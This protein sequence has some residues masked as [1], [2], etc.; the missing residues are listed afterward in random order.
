MALSIFEAA[1][2][3]ERT[4]RAPNT[5]RSGRRVWDDSASA[6]VESGSKTRDRFNETAGRTLHAVQSICDAL[7]PPSAG[8]FTVTFGGRT[9]QTHL[10]SRQ[11]KVT[12]EPLYTKGLRLADVADT[13]T[14]FVVHEIG[15][16]Q[17]SGDTDRLVTE[18]LTN[19]REY[20]R[21]KS[22][23]DALSNVLDDHALEVWAKHR[24]PGIAHTFRVTTKFVAQEQGLVN[25]PP[26]KWNPDADYTE[27]FNFMVVSV[28]YRWFT[29]WVSDPATKAERNW[30]VNWA[31]EYGD[32]S[33][34]AKR[35][36]G[37]KVGLARL[38]IKP[39]DRTEPEPE[40]EPQPD[41]SGQP[42]QSEDEDEAQPSDDQPD[43]FDLGDEDDDDD[44]DTTGGG[45]DDDDEEDGDG[46]DGED[47]DGES[48]EDDEPEHQPLD[49]D[50][51]GTGQPEDDDDTAESDEDEDGDD[52]I[53][54][55]GYKVETPDEA[56]D[57]NESEDDADGDESDGTDNGTD[58]DDDATDLPEGE[59]GDDDG[60]DEAEWDDDDHPTLDTDE[61]DLGK[62]GEGSDDAPVYESFEPEDLKPREKVQTLDDYTEERERSDGLRDRTLQKEVEVEMRATKVTDTNGYGSMKIEINL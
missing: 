21:W 9:A 2:E 6:Y 59:A 51:E 22:S 45:N 20:L 60:E 29:R 30:W 57:F 55:G 1:F 40:P 35:L 56:D 15:H 53:D 14:G 12:P 28:R 39:T 36:E 37:I 41:E 8:R 34:P 42:G 48:D 38:A 49:T 16:V 27:R 43:T 50:D 19:E 23:I 18:W 24:F 58:S 46:E 31:D 32:P 3:K 25:K 44:D 26:R 7:I 11:I 17:I 61:G 47:E 4:V 13:L 5:Y 52:G 62:E 10:A 54:E 33:D